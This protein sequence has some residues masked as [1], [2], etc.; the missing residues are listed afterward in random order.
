M[1]AAAVLVVLAVLSFPLRAQT[2]DPDSLARIKQLV[3]EERW[4][5]IVR[6]AEAEAAP[7]ADLNYYYGIAL[8]R[9]ERWGDAESAFE[10]GSTQQ[11]RDE[12]FPIELAGIRFRQKKYGEAADYLQRALR[13]DPADSYANDFLGS[14]YFLQGNLEAALKYWNRVSKPHVEQV[15][16]EPPPKVDRVLLD[17]AFVFSPAS[18]LRLSE[19]QT[20]EAR[21]GGLSIFPDRNFD[22]EAR[23][24]GKFDVV[25]RSRERN[26]W[27]ASKWQG[28]LSLFRGLPFQTIHPEFYNISG[29]A[30]NIVSLYRWDAQKRR[31]WTNLS[32]PF[33]GDPKWRYQL[34][35]DLRDE[36]WDI[37]DFSDDSALPG[38]LK[39]RKQAFAAGVTSFENGRWSW[40]TGVELSHRRFLDVTPDTAL[41]PQLLTEGFQLKHL[42]QTDYV[43]ARVPERRFVVS[44]GVSTQ[45]GRT[46]SQPS[47]AFAKL[48]GS[49]ETHWFP[50]AS[51]DDYEMEGKIR[52]GWTFGEVPFDELF[53]LGVER[54]NDLWLR[55]HVGTQDG[56][57]GNAPMGRNYFLSNWEFDK[58][59]YSKSLINLKLGPFLDIGRITDSSG[60]LGSQIWLWDLGMQAKVRVLGQSVRFSYGRDLRSVGDVF[61]VAFRR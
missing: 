18:V 14:V 29:R 17:H 42:G 60:R 15:Q 46:W 5:E 57:K 19:L 10:R 41:T 52:V 9:L 32:G 13:L 36:N 31:I 51:G 49:L 23:P 6:I 59:V 11:P 58:N 30:I 40:S 55:A 33:S 53:V 54:D 28:L 50:Q 44:T 48:Q 27:G 34:D 24:D 38:G 3:A 25:F 20:T 37:R 21:V 1:K 61:Y 39:L 4:Q 45:L 7:S 43:L 35:L 26:G 47:R 22:L 2:S 56:R 16:L 12:R 8:A